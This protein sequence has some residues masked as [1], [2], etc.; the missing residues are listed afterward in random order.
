M[1]TFFF[2]HSGSRNTGG[3]LQ[4]AAEVHV[5]HARLLGPG[6]VQE[7]AHG[8][9]QAAGLA[10]EGLQDAGVRGVFGL[11]LLE[12][13]SALEEMM[14]RGFL[15]SWATPATMRPM[16]ASFSAGGARASRRSFSARRSR[17]MRS[18]RR[19]M[20]MIRVNRARE[21]SKRGEDD[22]APEVEHGDVV[23]GD[24]WVNSRT[25]MMGLSEAA[26]M[27]RSARRGA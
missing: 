10:E 6:V 25:P 1:R 16:P 24:V 11:G 12:H 27:S 4:D 7:V 9:G 20:I 5:V 15:I 18:A 3:L 8:A 26:V 23:V 21:V 22:Q 2:S 14:P 17:L 19:M 13:S